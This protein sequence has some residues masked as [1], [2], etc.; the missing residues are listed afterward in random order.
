LRL[1]L[2]VF[3]HCCCG[4]SRSERITPVQCVHVLLLLLL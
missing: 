4:C 2:V 3:M 1:L